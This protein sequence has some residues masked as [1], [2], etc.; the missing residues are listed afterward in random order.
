[1]A[2]SRG[3][4]LWKVETIVCGVRLLWLTHGRSGAL[5]QVS[6]LEMLAKDT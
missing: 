5:D 1:M 2:V 4:P 3:K 6:T